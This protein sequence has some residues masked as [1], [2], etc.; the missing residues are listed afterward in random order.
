MPIDT[1]NPIEACAPQ[2]DAVTAPAV[3]ALETPEIDDSRA[4]GDWGLYQR[5]CGY[6]DGNKGI[7]RAAALALKRRFSLA[8]LGGRAQLAGGVYMRT[9]PSVFAPEFVERMA[10]ENASR[11]YKRYPWLE[12][13]TQLQLQLD[14]DQ[15]RSAPQQSTILATARR[16]LHVVPPTNGHG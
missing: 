4:A 14:Q 16:H 3:P 1:I 2:T 8:Y 7:E 9:R 12:Q 15:Y 11:R 13:L 6:I 10:L 5:R